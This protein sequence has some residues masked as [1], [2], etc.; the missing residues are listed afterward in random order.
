M[1]PKCQVQQE[2]AGVPYQGGINHHDSGI[3]GVNAP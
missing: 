3:R 2:I 1:S